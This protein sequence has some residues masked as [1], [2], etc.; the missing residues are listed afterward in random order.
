MADLSLEMPVHTKDLKYDERVLAAC[1]D[2]VA[3]GLQYLMQQVQ[4][5]IINNE[6]DALYEAL[7]HKLQR[8]SK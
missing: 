2:N 6:P 7:I 3:K 1:G 4:N 5:G 8:S